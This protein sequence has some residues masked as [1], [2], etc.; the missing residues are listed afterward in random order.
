MS[1]T[2]TSAFEESVVVDSEKFRLKTRLEI[3]RFEKK[4]RTFRFE[5]DFRLEFVYLYP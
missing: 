2:V 4:R 5:L 3:G 1:C